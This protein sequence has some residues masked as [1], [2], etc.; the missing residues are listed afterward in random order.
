M[1]VQFGSFG[2]GGVVDS[3]H[4]CHTSKAF[5][6]YSRQMHRELTAEF[7]Q[8]GMGVGEGEGEREADSVT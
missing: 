7:C 5:S 3:T 6:R 1:L 4:W 8:L 2:T